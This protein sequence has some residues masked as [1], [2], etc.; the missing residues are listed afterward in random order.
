MTKVMRNSGLAGT[1]ATKKAV[2][3]AMKSIQW[4]GKDALRVWATARKDIHGKKEPAGYGRLFWA[5]N[6][7]EGDS[8]QKGEVPEGGTAKK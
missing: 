7:N 8:P 1:N 3:G 6:K 4:F 2:T 5:K